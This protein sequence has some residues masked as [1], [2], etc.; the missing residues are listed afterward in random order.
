MP[1]L[2]EVVEWV[3]GA[4]AEQLAFLRLEIDVRDRA[5]IK[6]QNMEDYPDKDERV[7]VA[8]YAYL[9]NEQVPQSALVDIYNVPA[10][11]LRRKIREIRTARSTSRRKHY[12][13]A[14]ND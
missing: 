10:D 12:E 3:Y 13:G 5:L 6:K 4:N 1:D 7:E 9:G 8:A 11:R 14:E 2:K